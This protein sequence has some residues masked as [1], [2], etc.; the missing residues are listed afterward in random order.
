VKQ[1]LQAPIVPPSTL[2]GDIPAAL[3]AIVLRALERDPAL[4]YTT[5]AD[6]ADELEQ[7]VQQT[8]YQSR[9]LPALLDDLFGGGRTASQAVL[10]MITPALLLSAASSGTMTPVPATPPRRKRVM[11]AAIGAALLGTTLLGGA[12][13][14]LALG[15]RPVGSPAPDATRA[16]A[17]A[18]SSGAPSGTQA[19]SA[20]AAPPVAGPAIAGAQPTS[21]APS[22]SAVTAPGAGQIAVEPLPATASSGEPAQADAPASGPTETRSKGGS[23][24]RRH[25]RRQVREGETADRIARG[26]PI[27]PFAEAA[28]RRGRR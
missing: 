25:A 6:M 19:P 26:L 21:A 7:V 28:N 10:T 4:R 20:V 1:V 15:S 9:M 8:R 16:T 14:W 13:A 12:G 24:P 3:D 27:D 2:R 18:P 5:A 17:P 22:A 11:G 23:R